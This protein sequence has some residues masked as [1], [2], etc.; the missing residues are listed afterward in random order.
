LKLRTHGQAKLVVEP[1]RTPCIGITTRLLPQPR[2]PSVPHFSHRADTRI[3]RDIDRN[4]AHGWK[5]YRKIAGSF[6]LAMSMQ[7]S[8]RHRISRGGWLY[9][10]ADTSNPSTTFAPQYAHPSDYHAR[11]S[12]KDHIVPET[13]KEAR[14]NGH[15]NRQNSVKNS[16]L[17]RL[18]LWWLETLAAVVAIGLLVGIY[19]ILAAYDGEQIST[20]TA[21]I[22]LTAVVSIF[23]TANRVALANIASNIISQAKWSWFWSPETNPRVMGPPIKDMELFDEASRSPSGASL[24]LKNSLKKPALILP[25]VV[26]IFATATGPFVQQAVQLIPC[27]YHD[28]DGTATIPKLQS[29][30]VIPSNTSSKTWG[31]HGIRALSLPVKAGIISSLTDPNSNDSAIMFTC[32]TGNC[33]FP[34][35]KEDDGSLVTHRSI[36]FCSSCTDISSLITKNV[37]NNPTGAP[38]RKNVSTT[39]LLPNGQKVYQHEILQHT[40]DGWLSEWPTTFLD[41]SPDNF[42]FNWSNSKADNVSQYLDTSMWGFLNM[43]ILSMN[44]FTADRA[45]SDS[46]SSL[47]STTISAT[48]CTLYP[49]LKSYAAKIEGQILNESLVKISNLQP[50][51]D[52]MYKRTMN[53]GT[54]K[55]QQVVFPT[56]MISVPTPCLVD[57]RTYTA[58]NLSSAPD[59][60]TL[61]LRDFGTTSRPVSLGYNGSNAPPEVNIT[62]PREC[63]YA[64]EHYD[65][66]KAAQTFLKD[67]LRGACARRENLDTSLP[68]C[69][70]SFWLETLAN[71][72]FRTRDDVA[73]YLDD[74]AESLTRRFR[75]GVNADGKGEGGATDVPGVVMQTTVCFAV[76]WYWL[77][78]PTGLTVLATVA[79]LWE[80]VR[81]AFR[82]G[83]G[84]MVWKS[85][86]LPL[87]YHRER[88]VE[89]DG[90][91]AAVDDEKRDDWVPL[92]PL[93]DMEREA[94]RTRVVFQE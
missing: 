45:S 65:W 69:G 31:I 3:P 48:A 2:Q 86:L 4:Y 38:I 73:G 55:G 43:T 36:G 8:S 20:W 91:G 51:G 25:L 16:T 80:L 37:T 92:L 18:K 79:L 42:D 85:S 11:H 24:L 14:G 89:V 28:R 30:Y 44:N 52:L 13:E 40:A 57:G 76:R 77:I 90:Q 15:G 41:V 83:G 62:A 29:L 49:C 35:L 68:K 6:A 82:L 74:V 64:M 71:M 5:H 93:K 10:R 54:L 59:A 46:G 66:F 19:S 12:S 34:L 72:P 23:S 26:A 81:T 53:S 21:P 61:S 27:E 75:M 33:T 56:D 17:S 84:E 58:E 47:N 87:L 94:K 9:S 1:G 22:T 88:F 7:S 63:L 67:T 39:W 70:Q 60:I 32:T 50:Y 78:F